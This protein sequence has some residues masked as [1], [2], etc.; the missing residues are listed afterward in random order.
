MSK[1]YPGPAQMPQNSA[2]VYR[3]RAKSCTQLA[4][5]ATDADSKMLLLDM[6]QAWLALAEQADKNSAT[7]LVYETPEPRPQPAQQQQQ[8]PQPRDPQ[9]K[10]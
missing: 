4:H 9:N 5:N 3:V 7:T 1:E 8:Q 2:E 10:D 6:A